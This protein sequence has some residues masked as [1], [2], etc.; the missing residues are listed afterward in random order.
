MARRFVDGNTDSIELDPFP[1]SLDVPFTMAGWFNQDTNKT[2]T[3]LSV[4]DKD[5][6]DDYHR[7]AVRSTRRVEAGSFAGT[8]RF[9]ETSTTC[10]DGVWNHAVGLFIAD[11]NRKAYLNGGGEDQNTQSQDVLN[12]DRA[13][14]GSTADSTPIRY[15]DGM[16]AEL[17]I[18]DVELTLAE[19]T[20]LAAGY[21][22]LFVRPASLVFYVPLIRSATLNRVGADLVDDGTAVDDHPRMYYPGRSHIFHGGAAA[23]VTS[24][25]TITLQAAALAGVGVMLPSG[26][27]VLTLD[28]AVIAG[29]GVE[30]LP[31][32]G[33]IT[34]DASVIAGVGV[35]QPSGTGVIALLAPTLAGVGVLSIPGTGVVVLDGATLAGVG[36]MHPSATAAL[37]LDAA[38]MAGVGV[39]TIPGTAT[40]VLDAASLA[41]VG[42]MQPSATGVIT[43]SASV[44]AASG[45]S[46]APSGTGVLVLDAAVLAGVG[47]MLPSGT[48]VLVLD[49][50]VLAGVGVAAAV[51]GAPDHRGLLRPPGR[52]LH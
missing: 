23:A 9:A 8:F 5:V 52:M 15:W 44:I 6:T 46:G 42:V 22:P 27:G 1:G 4:A 32:T 13:I 50:V 33:V 2:H 7:L 26:A 28:A 43:L 11:N 35:M 25:G 38:T 36:V 12:I 45:T 18:W 3:I 10:S 37:V 24:T 19:I 31:G 21:S 30:K 49:V 16:L 29:V 34:L 20:I 41:A 39:Q 40:I 14:I 51:V 17:A 47:V 48:G